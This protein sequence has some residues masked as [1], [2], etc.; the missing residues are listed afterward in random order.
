MFIKIKVLY[1][2]YSE[3]IRYLIIGVLTTLISI[4]VYYLITKTLFNPQDKIELQIADI[5]SWIAAV[6]FA[7]FT[8]KI[9]VFKRKNKTSLKEVFS[10]FSSRIITLLIEMLI[11]FIFVSLLGFNDKIIKIIAQVIVII[12]NYVFSK[13]IVFKNN[14]IKDS[15]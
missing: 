2:K 5:I 4:L 1:N 8:N 12:L 11:M 7:F 13:F 6:T 14:L 3:I 9:I 10:F 15:K